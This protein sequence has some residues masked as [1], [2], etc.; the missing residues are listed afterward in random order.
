M[1][2]PSVSLRPP[3]VAPR[4]HPEILK[5]SEV[6][7]TPEKIWYFHGFPL[8]EGK[9]P[10]FYDV[11]DMPGTK[12]LQD[13]YEAIR[14][15]ILSFY[16]DHSDKM[17][18]QNVPYKYND[19]GWIAHTLYAFGYKHRE[20]CK[21][22]PILDSVV[23]QIPNAICVTVSILR[24]ETRIHAHVGATSALVRTHLGIYIPGEY[25]EVGIRVGGYGRGWADGELFGIEMARRHYAWNNTDE[26]RIALT[27]DTVKDEYA[28]QTENIAARCIS[29]LAMQKISSRF[30][31]TKKLPRPI[32]DVIHWGGAQAVKV[33]LKYQRI[34]GD[35]WLFVKKMPRS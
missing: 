29:L 22:L 17:P 26:M 15:E 24:P 19:P 33:M 27:V 28:D 4:N 10:S 13:N 25:P 12:L 6:P 20:R 5:Q 16:R 34:K 18:E 7:T 30:V 8:Y 23:R 31:F 1:S 11:S 32:L 9:Y 14:D 3:V 21:D 2:R 35:T